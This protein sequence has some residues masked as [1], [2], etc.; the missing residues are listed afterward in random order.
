MLLRLPLHGVLHTMKTLAAQHVP[1]AK[2]NVTPY[3]LGF[4]QLD[5]MSAVV[6][7]SVT[8]T[9][10]PTRNLFPCNGAVSVALLCCFS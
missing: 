5:P 8:D 4:K 6:Q 1:V 3:T 10:Q 7:A 9:L 2:S